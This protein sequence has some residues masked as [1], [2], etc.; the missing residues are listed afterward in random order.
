VK[1]FKEIYKILIVLILLFIGVFFVYP[2]IKKDPSLKIFTPADINPKLLDSIIIGNTL[3]HFIPDF[4]LYNQDGDKVTQK[5][6]SDKIYVSSFFFTTCNNICPIMTTNMKILH[7]HF[8]FDDEISFISHTVTPKIDSIS[9]LK[10]Y[11]DLFKIKTS[12]WM[13]LTGEKKQIYDLARNSYFATTTKGDGSDQDFIHT[14][15]FVLIDKK[16]R[17]RGFYDGTSKE[18][19]KRL[20]NEINILK[21]EYLED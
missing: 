17:I 2:N 20:I 8:L 6:L 4:D 11:S 12:K 7:D 19:T 16:K 5:N 18:D 9:V 21:S 10:A 3:Q 15:N 13:L 1:F 14:E